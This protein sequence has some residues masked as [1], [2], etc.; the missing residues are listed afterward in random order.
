MERPDFNPGQSACIEYR[1]EVADQVIVEGC[2]RWV[3]VSFILSLN[4]LIEHKPS[5]L[6]TAKFL[7]TMKAL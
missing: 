6:M 3:G 2:L 4:N 1:L 7:S 5:V